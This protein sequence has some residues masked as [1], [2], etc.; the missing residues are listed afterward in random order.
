[1][2]I[3][4][5]FE[6]LG[7]NYESMPI[8]IPVDVSDRGY[9]VK[10]WNPDSG[11]FEWS[12]L[13]KIVRKSPSEAYQVSSAAGN[14]LSSKDHMVWSR[15]EEG[16]PGWAFVDELVGTS[17]EVLTDSLGMIPASVTR[18]KQTIDVLDIE[19]DKNNSYVSNG[20]VSHNT[21]YGDPTVTPGGWLS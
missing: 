4:E 9:E 20:I 12:L 17:C 8:D 16:E 11:E 5:L 13:K 6:D 2:R 18:T 19:I 15:I 14:F 10:S 3:K 1:M 21:M 7:H